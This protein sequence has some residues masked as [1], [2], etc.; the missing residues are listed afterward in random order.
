ME[1]VWYYNKIKLK[2]NQIL[3]FSESRKCPEKIHYSDDIWWQRL[4]QESN[5]KM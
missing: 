2:H 1:A 3:H 4:L 5:I